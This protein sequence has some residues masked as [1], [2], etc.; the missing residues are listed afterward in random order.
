MK[1]TQ[2]K[3]IEAI[4]K[5]IAHHEKNLKLA[6]DAKGVF[7]NYRSYKLGIVYSHWFFVSIGGQEI[8]Y[9]GK[10]CAL[11][12]LYH[13]Q[14]FHN[15]CDSCPLG[16][17]QKSECNSITTWGMLLESSTKQEFITAEKEM[18]K[19]LKEVLKIEMKKYDLQKM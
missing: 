14:L 17:Y 13:N 18:I 7:K 9:D 10:N 16:D 5:S 19:T 6:Q 3:K 15:H 8:P 1:I 2:Y 4:K 12:Q 11:C